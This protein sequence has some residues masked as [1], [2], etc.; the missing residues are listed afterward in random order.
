MIQCMDRERG[1]VQ[2]NPYG[3]TCCCTCGAEFIF[4]CPFTAR[5]IAPTHGLTIRS[6]AEVLLIPQEPDKIASPLQIAKTLMY[7]RHQSTTSIRGILQSKI[8][9]TIGW[10]MKW[11]KGSPTFYGLT[12]E[13]VAKVVALCEN[14]NTMWFPRGRTVKPYTWDRENQRLGHDAP[15]FD[16]VMSKLSLA[17]RGVVNAAARILRYMSYRHITLITTNIPNAPLA[18][19]VIRFG[20]DFLGIELAFVDGDTARDVRPEYK[21]LLKNVYSWGRNSNGAHMNWTVADREA[22]SAEYDIPDLSYYTRKR[23]LK[24]ERGM[25]STSLQSAYEISK[26]PRCTTVYE[27][28]EE[29][30]D[31]VSSR[32]GDSSA[33][34][35]HGWWAPSS[36]PSG[37]CDRDNRRSWNWGDRHYQ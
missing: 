29:D 23:R 13:G 7:G 14:G 30:Y 8:K 21:A 9:A 1:C 28:D 31:N 34:S 27:V 11:M 6:T 26:H 32:N 16:Y 3:M 18:A 36:R 12:D 15:S 25:K 37:W 35:H 2:P 19:E 4:E 17:E 24:V 22:F 33:C 10:V 20:N 5:W